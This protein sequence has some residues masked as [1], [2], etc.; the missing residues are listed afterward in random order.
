MDDDLNTPIVISHLFEAVSLVNKVNDGHAK[1]TAEDVEQL[2]DLFQTYLFDILGI[3]DEQA[4]GLS[5]S[6]KDAMEP[7]RG[8]VDLLLKLRGDA[9][10]KKDWAT[11]DLIRDQLAALGFSVKDT[12]NG[13]EWSLK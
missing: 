7:Y 12:K 10:A 2:R 1:A 4:G 8:A 6:G 3:V 11:S 9:K 13:A 5:A